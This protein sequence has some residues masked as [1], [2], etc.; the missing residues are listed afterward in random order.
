MRLGVVIQGPLI[1]YGQGPNNSIGGFDT[2]ETILENVALLNKYDIRYIISTWTPSNMQ[3]QNILDALKETGVRVFH[4]RSPQEF[5][6]DHRYKQH[7]GI[8][9]GAEILLEEYAGITHFARIRTDMLMPKLFWEWICTTCNK[10]EERL[11]VSELMD[12]PFYQGDFIYLA[13]RAVFFAFLTTVVDY[14]GRIIHPSIAF[15]MGIKHCEAR[16]FGYKYGRGQSGQIKF[17][18]DFLFRPSVVR[19]NWNQFI[20]Q[21]MGT[22]PGEI[23]LDIKWR[24]RRIG[25]FLQGAWFKFDNSGITQ[26][27]RF[28]NNIRTL[29]RE[30]KIYRTKCRKN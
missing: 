5:D 10:N 17:L 11:Y 20:A 2:L 6:P 30:Y 26:R 27:T 12:R 15:D 24:D 29:F 25:S 4:S 18:V 16:N 13:K 9:R 21:Y 22:M 7:F 23:W 1:S 8:L 28:L 19:E 14:K 3:E